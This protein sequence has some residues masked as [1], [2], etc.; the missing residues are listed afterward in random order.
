MGYTKEQRKAYY[1]ANK[2][3]ELAQS[4]A[5]YAANKEANKAKKKAYDAVYNAANK[6]RIRAYHF[7]SNYGLTLDELDALLSKGCNV[8]G[9]FERLHVDHCHETLK[10]RGCLCQKCNLALGHY[11]KYILPNLDKFTKYLGGTP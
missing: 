10:V 9:S 2:E 11:E 7:K 4:K 3:R 6:D 5:Y 8:C 1:E